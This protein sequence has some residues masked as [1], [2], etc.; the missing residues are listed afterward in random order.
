MIFNIVLPKPCETFAESLANLQQKFNSTTDPIVYST[1]T[2][3][4]LLAEWSTLG[5]TLYITIEL[6]IYLSY[7]EQTSKLEIIGTQRYKAARS[8]TATL[9]RT[10]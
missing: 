5:K 8:D 4:A 10:Q 2:I 3:L 9:H 1:N 7:E 6:K